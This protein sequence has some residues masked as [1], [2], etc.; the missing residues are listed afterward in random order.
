[1]RG[2][3]VA[4]VLAAGVT[5][6]LAF[7]TV[8]ELVLSTTAI[9]IPGAPVLPES[10]PN[11]E[12]DVESTPS[13]DEPIG[14]GSGP[15]LEPWDGSSRVN[16][17]V[18]GGDFGIGRDRDGPPHSDTMIVLT[19]DPNSKTA[20]ML[21][22]PRDLWVDIPTFGHG[23]INTAYFWGE[24]AQLPGGGA[25][26]AVDT[27]EQFLGITIHYYVLVDFSAFI[28]FIDE[29]GGA[30]V[31][32]P[33]PILVDPIY[34]PPR[35]LEVGIQTLP[36]D[37]ALAYAR[38]RN[39]EG[40]DFDRAVRQ[41]QVLIAVRNQLLRSDVQ[42][43]ILANGLRIFQELSSGITTNITFNE[44]LK[45]GLLAKDIDLDNIKRGVIAPP[46]QVILDKS[47][48][49]LDILK[50]VTEKI[51]ELRDEIFST[52]VA[53]GP[54]IIGDDPAQL[55]QAEAAAVGI[56]NGTL[57]EGLA[58][59][60]GD[61]LTL[62][63]VNVVEVG[64][65]LLTDATTIIDYTG[66]PYTVQFLVDLMQISNTKIYNRY[67]PDSTIDVEVIIGPDWAIPQ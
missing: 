42:A 62:Q 60:T 29:I 5:A 46:E 2:L 32:V 11:P 12:G 17:L 24:G 51:R 36:G 15:E 26:L 10:N 7:R 57:T 52:G 47:P 33:E 38:A 58:G 50:P 48:D 39:T 30:K 20:G 16:I 59:A 23:K 40:G 56:Y 35:T 13:A 41:Q 63:G 14:G 19:I 44:A 31:D 45:L 4:F 9:E 3:L 34:G 25:G 18:M 67:D 53:V 37:L 1:M 66:N 27:V 22:L 54:T 43:H 28:G 64:N 8:R 21:S 61:Y 65:A 6:I 55:M 49:G